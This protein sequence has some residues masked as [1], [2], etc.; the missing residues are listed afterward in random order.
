[1]NQHDKAWI[2]S[3]YIILKL[4]NRVA[5]CLSILNLKEYS[6]EKWCDAQFNLGIFVVII[7]TKIP[8]YTLYLWHYSIIKMCAVQGWQLSESDSCND[9]MVRWCLTQA[10][11]GQKGVRFLAVSQPSWIVSFCYGLPS[12]IFCNCWKYS[13]AI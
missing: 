5:I 4:F 13:K 9:A 11:I 8:L 6:S 10:L 7:G 3:P 1:M 2:L 12:I